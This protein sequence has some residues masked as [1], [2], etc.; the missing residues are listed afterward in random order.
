MN[1]TAARL[2]ILSFLLV[3]VPDAALGQGQASS[4]GGPIQYQQTATGK[5]TNDTFR[6]IYTFEGRKGD[7]ID[8]TLT[9]TDGT[10]DPLLI[11]TA[12][13]NNLL[14]MQDSGA[15]FNASISEAQLP[16]DG[17]YFLIVTRF[18]QQHGLTTGGYSLTLT[19]AGVANAGSGPNNAFL[20]YGD[21][22]VGE[23]NS[24]QFQ[25]IY[26]FQATRG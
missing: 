26:A 19:L 11:L 12:D 10:L 1:T 20:Q 2:V 18:G 13:Q 16:R 15:N 24:A 6:I 14:A 8:A 23:I 25:Q 3:T 7:I 17:N 4:P 22:V 5:L 21:S 9:P